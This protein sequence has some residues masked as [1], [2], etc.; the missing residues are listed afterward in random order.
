MILFT[1]KECKI[2]AAWTFIVIIPKNIFGV[3]D[4]ELNPTKEWEKIFLC[5]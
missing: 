3:R 5:L 2:T 1:H 4:Y